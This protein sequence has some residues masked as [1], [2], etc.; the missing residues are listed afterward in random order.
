M[1]IS[2]AMAYDYTY[3]AMAPLPVHKED[4][5]LQQELLYVF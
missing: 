5:Q 1:R 4:P 3:L 2:V